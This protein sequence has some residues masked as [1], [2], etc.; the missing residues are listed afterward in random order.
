[1]TFSE[2]LQT[3]VDLSEVKP[4]D[5]LNYRNY[6]VSY[7]TS[8]PSGLLP[9]RHEILMMTKAAVHVSERGQ[10]QQPDGDDYGS[11][12]SGVS[13]KNAGLMVGR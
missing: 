1:M 11:I 9:K 3:V 13:T 4:T 5:R 7:R 6:P 12:A 10:W 8:P 2:A